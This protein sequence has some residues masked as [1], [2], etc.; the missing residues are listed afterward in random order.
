MSSLLR[1]AT[2]QTTGTNICTNIGTYTILY[3]TLGVIGFI[4]ILAIIVYFVTRVPSGDP[5]P[6]QYKVGPFGNFYYEEVNPR[7][8]K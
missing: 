6:P 3:I 4:V 2:N 7:T 1:E 8:F 5:I